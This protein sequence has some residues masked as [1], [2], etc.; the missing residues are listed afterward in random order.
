MVIV[1]FGVAGSG[2]STVGSLLAEGLGWKFVDADDYHSRENIEKMASGISLDDD[3]RQDWLEALRSIIADALSQNEGLVM[4]CSA[5]KLAYREKL[6]MSD[7]VKFVLL[8]ADI[9][10]IRGRLALRKGHFMGG[11]MLD[12][13]FETLEPIG[14]VNLVIDASQPPGESV[15]QIRQMMSNHHD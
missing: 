1:L 3:D 6:G 5:L 4:A 8:K 9:S 12:S 13:Q 7:K 2:K 15:G 11:N 10:L 14:L